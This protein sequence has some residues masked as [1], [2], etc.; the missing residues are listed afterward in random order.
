M[1]EVRSLQVDTSN[2]TWYINPKDQHLNTH[3]CKEHKFRSHILMNINLKRK[4][5]FGLQF[6]FIPST[7]SHNLFL[8][9]EILFYSFEISFPTFTLIWFS[10][11][12][13]WALS[14]RSVELNDH[15]LQ[16]NMEFNFMYLGYS[17]PVL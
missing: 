3:L 15:I 17:I 12:S 13:K 9:F 4:T 8:W 5:L 11:Y 2:I 6:Y 10:E 1:S 14:G 16:G 7:R